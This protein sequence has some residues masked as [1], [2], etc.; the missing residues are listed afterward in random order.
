MPGLGGAEGPITHKIPWQVGS[1]PWNI[2]CPTPALSTLQYKQE[3][4]RTNQLPSLKFSCLPRKHICKF[5][6]QK[7]KIFHLA[8]TSRCTL[9]TDWQDGNK[10]T[11]SMSAPTPQVGGVVGRWCTMSSSLSAAHL[12]TEHGWQRETLFQPQWKEAEIPA[13]LYCLI[14]MQRTAILQILYCANIVY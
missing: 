4:T 2:F 5:R 9:R 7:Q 6:K 11:E 12:N 10:G 3:Q 1:S 14:F 13:D 8:H